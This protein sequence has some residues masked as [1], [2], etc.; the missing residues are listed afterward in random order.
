[1]TGQNYEQGLGEQAPEQD[2][3]DQLQNIAGKNVANVKFTNAVNSVSSYTTQS[4]NKLQIWHINLYWRWKKVPKVDQDAIVDAV[5]RLPY[6]HN[7]KVTEFLTSN[8]V[9]WLQHYLNENITDKVGLKERL[10]KMWISYN[11]KILED[12]KFGPQTLEALKFLLGMKELRPTLP[13]HETET[14]PTPWEI[15]TPPQKDHP[16]DPE[17]KEKWD[18]ERIRRIMETELNKIE[19]TNKSLDWRSGR[20]GLW[21]NVDIDESKNKIIIRT[22][23]SDTIKP[24]YCEIDRKTGKLNIICWKYSYESPFK[25]RAFNLDGSWFPKSTDQ[26]NAN[27]IRWFTRIWD[28]M[29]KLKNTAVYQNE[30][31]IEYQKVLLR[32]DGMYR[33]NGRGWWWTDTLIVRREKLQETWRVCNVNL[34]DPDMQTKIASLLTAMKLDLGRINWKDHVKNSLDNNHKN[35][36]K[37]YQNN[38]TPL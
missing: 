1:M 30:W 36:V 6:P 24:N 20:N 26:Q 17:Q 29:N 37:Y 25:L 19:D 11:G 21:D 2:V 5:N 34:L 31:S 12:W 10:K 38:K 27:V 4:V 33:N 13:G 35:Y 23:E 22:R 8:N 7:D 32:E 28:L 18:S 15:D 14:P 9:E 16:R 3:A